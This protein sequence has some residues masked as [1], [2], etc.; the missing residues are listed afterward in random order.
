[1]RI[2]VECFSGGPEDYFIYT[3]FSPNGDNINDF[4]TIRNVE[5][6]TNNELIIYNRWGNL[7]FTMNNYNNG[8]NGSFNNSPLPDG[9]YFYV[10]RPGDGTEV[11][12]YLV[13]SR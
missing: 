1:V 12:G 13:I 5:Q 11:A 4:F 10:F 2:E 6:L 8:W 3:G 7:V 9:T